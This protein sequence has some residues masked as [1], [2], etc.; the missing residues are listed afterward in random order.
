MIVIP[1]TRDLPG[2]HFPF[3]ISLH[4]LPIQFR[5]NLKKLLIVYI[6]LHGLAQI[7]ISEHLTPYST[8]RPLR[9]SHHSML[10]VPHTKQRKVGHRAFSVAAPW[11]PEAIR[12]A[13]TVDAFKIHLKTH[14]YSLASN[15][16]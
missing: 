6:S 3:T 10:V 14:V 15:C 11:L 8:N 2:Y 16:T 9:F 7:H 5:I 4:L 13:E 12:A 1:S